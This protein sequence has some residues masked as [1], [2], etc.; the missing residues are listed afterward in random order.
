MSK[1]RDRILEDFKIM[2]ADLEADELPVIPAEQAKALRFYAL[3]SAAETNGEKLQALYNAFGVLYGFRGG[4]QKLAAVLGTDTITL[5][6]QLSAIRGDE[7]DVPVSGRKV[8]DS[9]IYKAMKALRKELL[10]Y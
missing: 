2:A 3:A 7:E 6:S 10:V 4:A 1:R 8:S 5:K 9:R